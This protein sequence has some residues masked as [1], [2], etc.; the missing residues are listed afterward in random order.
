MRVQRWSVEVTL[1]KIGSWGELL[2]GA[3]NPKLVR[4]GAWRA[5][6]GREVHGRSKRAGTRMRL[7]PVH[8][9]AWHRPS[10]CCA[11]S[12]LQLKAN[13]RCGRQ[14]L[15]G[16]VATCHGVEPLGS[17]WVLSGMQVMGSS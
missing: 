12:V 4:V 13:G 1:C 6:M 10:E 8:A 11:V 5:G 3:E 9:G 17:A 16:S 14:R 7:W 2:C 15:S